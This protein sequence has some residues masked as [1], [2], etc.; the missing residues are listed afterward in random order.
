[1]A[2]KHD[3]LLPVLYK[4]FD[5]LSN[6]KYPGWN[7]KPFLFFPVERKVTESNGEKP[8]QR[9]QTLKC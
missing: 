6:R 3:K 4:S 1:M 8:R 5:E 2:L 9:R 7:L